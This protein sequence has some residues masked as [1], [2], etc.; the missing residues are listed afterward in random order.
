VT[1]T[2]NTAPVITGSIA[3]TTVEACSIAAAPAAQTTVSG[4]EALAGNITITDACT[5][6]ANITVSHSDAVSGSCPIV[7]T[8]TYTVTD[9][10]GNS[11][12]VTHII[13]IA[14]TTPPTASNPVP[15]TVSGTKPS[16]DITVVTDEADN[17][18]AIPTVSW[19]SDVSNGS[20]PEIVTRI[21]R[22]ADNCGNSINVTQLITVTEIIAPIARCKPNF[23]VQLSNVDGTATITANDIDNGSSDNCGIASMS[24][25]PNT[26]TCANIGNNAVTLTVTDIY[27]NAATCASTVIVEAPTI[28]SGTLTGYL[29]TDDPANASDII[30]ITSC[31]YDPIT[32]APAVN[33]AILN[34]VIPIEFQDDIIRWEFSVNGGYSW[35][36]IANTATS[37]TYSNITVTTLVRVVI[38]VGTCVEYSPRVILNVIPP[39]IKPTIIGAT[40]FDSCLGDSVTVVAQSEYANNQLVDEGGLFNFANPEDW[41]IDG[42]DDKIMPAQA[43]TTSPN[44]WSESTSEKVFHDIQY[45][46]Q[47]GKKFAIANGNYYTTLETPIFNTLGLEDVFLSF[48]QSYWLQSGAEIKIEISTDGGMTYN[49]ILDPGI[50]IENGSPHDY[51]GPSNTGTL[52]GTPP[53]N[54]PKANFVHTDINLQDYIGLTNLRIRFTF[55]SGGTLASAWALDNVSLPDTPINEVIEW[56]DSDGNVV[57]TGYTTTITTVTPG[58]Q[59]YGATALINSCR[60]PGDEGTEFITI[61]ASLAY[62]GEAIFPV[63]GE[64]GDNKVTLAA[65]DNTK[66]AQQNYDNGVWK[67]GVYIYP[68]ESYDHDNDVNT[69]NRVGVDYPGTGEIGEWTVTS[70]PSSSCG[71]GYAFSNKNSPTSTFTGE[72][73]TYTLT[74]TVAGCSSTVQVTINSCA[75]IDFDGDNDYVTF[76][77]NYDFTGPFSIEAWIKPESIIGTQ[78]IF[79]KRDANNLIDGYDLSLNGGIVSFNW[80]NGSSISSSPSVIGTDR[81]YHIAITFNGTVY[82]MYIDGIEIKSANGNLPISNGV[83]CLLG[84]MV[85]TNFLPNNTNNQ[86]NGWMDEF[87]IWNKALDVQHLRQMMNQEVKLSGSDDVMGEVIPI[88]VSG[89]DIGLNGTDDDILLWSHLQGYYRFDVGCGYLTAYKGGLNGRLRNIE[90]DYVQTAPIPYTSASDGNWNTMSTWAQPIVWDAPN[91]IGV[92]GVPIDWNI[93]KI[94]HNINSGNKDITVLGLISDTPNKILTMA[95]P[96]VTNPIENNDGQGLWIT[97]YLKLNGVIDLVGE[98]QLVQKRYGTYDGLGNFS[99]TQFSESIFDETSSG[100]IERDQQGQKNSFNYN[101][102]SSPVSPQNATA[103]NLPYSVGGILKDGTISSAFPH[104]SITFGEG[105]YFAD[106]PNTI[107][108]P[109]KISNRWI[110]SYNG[111]IAADPWDNY[112]QWKYIGSTVPIKAGEGYTMK[113]TGGPADVTVMQ[114]YVFVGKPHSGDITNLSI[115]PNGNYLIGNPYPSALDADEFILD[116]LSTASGGRNTNGNI[117]NGALYFWD[118]FKNTDNHLLAQYTGGYA[119]Y[120][121]IGQVWAIANIPLGINNDSH[122]DKVPKRYIPVG[123]AFFVEAAFDNKLVGSETIV[124]GGTLIFK[125]NQR[126]FVK[127]SSGKSVFMKGVKAKA[128]TINNEEYIDS[129]PKIRLQ[130][131]SPL[132]YQRG[133]LVGVDERTTNNFDIGFD[134]PLNENNKEDMFWQLGKGKLVIQGVN[135]FDENQELPLGLKIAKTGLATIKIQEVQNIDENATLHIKDKFTGKTHNI[136]HKTFEIELEPGTYLDRFSLIL[137][138]Q[139]LVAEDLGTDILLVEPVI[140]DH[141][142]HVFMNNTIAE[143]QI[144]NN[145]TDEIKSILLYNYLGQT[146]NTWN[147]NLNRRI[148]SLPV[149]LATGVYVVQ[150][151]TIKGTSINKRIIIE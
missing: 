113:G 81:W 48:D 140:E 58:I 135:N 51:T 104:V 107:G 49:T 99:T 145:G 73:G 131:D 8:R 118:H 91:S 112:Y 25:S 110:W 67:L 38:Q 62:A 34:L 44:I 35:S 46:T 92:N 116:N 146:M 54:I 43:S 76:Y 27:G 21:Y 10:S 103:N 97:H 68:G 83:E 30:D 105:A 41:R 119:T 42:D 12:T 143:L 74:W 7:I 39:E 124:D 60:A 55:D 123:Q 138:Y 95:D 141:N 150:I 63:A 18:T 47:D 69:P 90:D 132:G 79:S 125:N 11:S 36:P 71:A 15:I 122:G 80:N 120:N 31:P 17:C 29:D 53:K 2:D 3:L 136:S 66:T 24:V 121:L 70:A 84:A 93:V 129:R 149:K 134:A 28:D 26:F 130:F 40:E 1:V 5:A 148:I 96:T 147:A 142:Y 50:N 6:D 75:S 61:K 94:S 86:F 37:Y 57:T 59:A 32:G 98:S 64:C 111:S 85:K 126:A 45:D 52:P 108:S 23:T 77:D 14:D 151:N 102:W 100:N 117:F 33:N 82:K 109:I 115:A 144:K 89:S 87:R 139:K 101:Y 4:L 65:Y 88:K 114:N 56:T 9:A 106:L 133:L 128:T 127:E 19:V 22:V 72:V 78:S 16:P 137:K 13:N 20:C